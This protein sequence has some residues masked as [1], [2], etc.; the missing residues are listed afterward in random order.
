M[1]ILVSAFA[2]NAEYQQ[3]YSLGFETSENYSVG[4]LDGQN[5]WSKSSD[6]TAVQVADYGY[7][8]EQSAYLSG[9]NV[10]EQLDISLSNP[11][12]EAMWF[13]CM[14]KPS[15][16]GQNVAITLSTEGNRII[17]L[18]LTRSVFTIDT[19]GYAQ[20]GVTLGDEWYEW[21]VIFEPK[22]KTI[23]KVYVG[24]FEMV[25]SG[26]T[27]KYSSDSAGIPSRIRIETEWNASDAD[28][29]IDDITFAVAPEPACL[30]LLALAGLFF[31]RK[32]S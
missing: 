3:I 15:P 25:P 28:A 31:L 1:L 30:G 8:S 17:K 32:R 6:K 12:N 24:D 16:A 2:A 23:S 22:T 20:M 5:G 11:K 21:G 10:A 4:S 13:R 14:T 27:A 29:Y 7:D 19:K 26:D 9:A 18:N